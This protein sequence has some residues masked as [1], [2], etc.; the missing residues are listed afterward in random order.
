MTFIV[1]VG[2]A[3]IFN[4]YLAPR[5]RTNAERWTTRERSHGHPFYWM[6][7]FGDKDSVYDYDYPGC[8]KAVGCGGLSACKAQHQN[9]YNRPTKVEYNVKNVIYIE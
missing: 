8:N 2:V 7:R 3:W 1:L 5:W 6:L 4:P 9:V